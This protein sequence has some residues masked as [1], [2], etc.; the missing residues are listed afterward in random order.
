V[1]D[2]SSAL[3]QLYAVEP[4]AFVAERK[5]L[6]RALREEGRAEEADE[7]AKRRKPSLPVFAANRLARENPDDVADLLSAAERLTAAHAKGD[8]GALRKEQAELAARVRALVRHAQEA[9]GRPLSDA[10]EERLAALLRAAASDP[11]AAALLRRGML[12]EELEPAAFG[13]LAG[14]PLQPAK[15]RRESGRD[16]ERAR[17]QKRQARVAELEDQLAEAQ[18]EVEQAKRE[19]GKAEREVERAERRVATLEGQLGDARGTS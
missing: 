16:A 1:A 9:A 3:E 14:V 11:D 8:S 15:P 12:S 19:L 5:R 13:A 6:E 7:L 4:E 17:E 18:S 10:V 2:D